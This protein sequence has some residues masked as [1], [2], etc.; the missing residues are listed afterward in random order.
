MFKDL[1]SFYENLKKENNVEYCRIQSAL[2]TF[3]KLFKDN[4]NFENAEVFSILFGTL[5]EISVLIK[6]FS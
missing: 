4:L 1:K 5:N 2:K 3:L 6:N